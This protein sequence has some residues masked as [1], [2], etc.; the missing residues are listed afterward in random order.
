[1]NM[2]LKN[3]TNVSIDA[4][5]LAEARRRRINL[6]AALEARLREEI[7]ASR[8]QEW[9]AAN[10]P[11]LEDANEFLARHGLWSDGQRQF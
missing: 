1:M 3:R 10:R 11:A 4:G 5:L 8:Q 9:L 2:L 6:S 7:R